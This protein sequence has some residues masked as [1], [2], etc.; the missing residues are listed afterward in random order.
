MV[1]AGLTKRRQA[2]ALQKSLRKGAT[3]SQHFSPQISDLCDPFR[4]VPQRKSAWTNFNTLH[5]FP[6]A[7]CG[8]WCSWFCPHSIS[9]REGCA[10]A[11]PAGVH[12]DAPST[13]CFAEL[14]RKIHRIA[15][16]QYLANPICEPK[17]RAE[18]CFLVQR[19]DNMKTL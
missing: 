17:D 3:F 2:V 7:W 6:G 8:N 14:L 1:M 10:I 18:I 16:D 11:V 9:T 12:Q 19:N 15:T 5:F 13:I 4:H